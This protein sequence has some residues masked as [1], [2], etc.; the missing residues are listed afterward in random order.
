MIPNWLVWVGFILGLIASIIAINDKIRS[1]LR[2]GLGAE[3][4]RTIATLM[5]I[6]AV[7]VVCTTLAFGAK[8]ILNAP[9]T[10]G[11]S[12]SQSVLSNAS[13]DIP[14]PTDTPTPV[15][16]PL[17]IQSFAVD[18]TNIPVF[19]YVNFTVRFNRP[20]DSQDEVTLQLFAGNSFDCSSQGS[21][22]TICLVSPAPYTTTFEAALINADQILVYRFPKTITINWYYQPTGVDTPEDL[23]TSTDSAEV[24][25]T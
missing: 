23:C 16:S 20:W 5:S 21:V 19:S 11:N 6:L 18:R 7:I 15:P 12:N 2:E 14:I 10:S 9:S 4:G 1:W 13:T 17:T 24:E 3:G 22:C 8:A 25:P